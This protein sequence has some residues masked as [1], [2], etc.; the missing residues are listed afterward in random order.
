M[1][2]LKVIKNFIIVPPFLFDLG[3]SERQSGLICFLLIDRGVA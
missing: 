2:F 1:K 3:F